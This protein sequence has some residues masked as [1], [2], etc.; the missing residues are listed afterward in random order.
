MKSPKIVFFDTKPY[1]RVFFDA[2]DKK[3]GFPIKYFE[4]HPGPETAALARGFNTVCIFV[5]DVVSA[6][7]MK[8]LHKNG[9]RLIAL[10]CAG[11]NNVDF[12]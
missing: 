11:Y 10:R 4:E 7:L 2:A 5:N 6:G 3:F 1:D 8:T 9:I 12:R